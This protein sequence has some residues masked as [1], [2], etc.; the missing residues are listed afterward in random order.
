MNIKYAIASH[1]RYEMIQEQSLGFLKKHNI[2]MKDVYIF[3][4][5]ESLE[6][7]KSLKKSWGVN[8]IRSEG[9]I[10]DVRNHIIKYFK[11]GQKI[12]E[13]DDDVKD[14][15]KM[16]PGRKVSSIDNLSSFIEE[17]FS[18]LCDNKGLWGINA[19]DNN[20]EGLSRGKDKYGSYSIINSFCG[21]VNDK[22]ITLTV[23][24]KEDFDRCAQFV[25]MDIPILKRTGYGVQT[26]YWKNEGGIQARYKEKKRIQMQ[27]K[28]AKLLMKKFPK[29]FYSTT[30]KNGIVDIKF[31]SPRLTLKN[32]C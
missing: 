6:E 26:N 2:P 18:M 23:P 9:R 32:K 31:R 14:I 4:S 29:Y 24:E 10:K 30:R 7:Y 27:R 21:Y 19:N 8:L 17:S 1:M 13:L 28:S 11:S 20:R 22:R 3:C 25:E 12:I 5:P 15:V 16:V